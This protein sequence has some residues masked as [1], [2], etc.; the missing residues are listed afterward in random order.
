MSDESTD[1]ERLIGKRTVAALLDVT[2]RQVERYVADPDDPLPVAD[3]APQGSRRGHR[4]DIRA[5]YEWSIGRMIGG[6]AD[7]LD[8]GQERAR[9]AKVQADRQ[10]IAL[11]R[12]RGELV[13]IEHV[14][15]VVGEEYTRVRAR[16]LAVP[17]K[18]APLVYR[19]DTIAEV[20]ETLDNA[21]R[22]AL[23]ELSDPEN[24]DGGPGGGGESMPAEAA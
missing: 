6:D 1:N 14:A 9:L 4:F 10:E 21:V 11:E 24:M 17:P 13:P 15:D 12:E 8:L 20:R 3:P 2:V 16:L 18:C 22:E 19:A 23:A 5:V 7:M